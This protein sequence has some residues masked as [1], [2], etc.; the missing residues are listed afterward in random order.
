[1]MTV[2][3]VSRLTGVTVRTLQ[4]YDEIGLLPPAG[5]TE[6]GYRLYDRAAL[7]RLQQ[8]LLYRELRFPLGEIRR[9]LSAPDFDRDLALDQQ[10]G[11]LELELEHLEGL[12]RFARTI[13]TIGVR[14]LDFTAFDRKKQREYARRAKAQWGGSEAYR[15]YEEK[16]KGRSE[17]EE[18]G[19]AAGLMGIFRAFGAVKDGAPDSAE[20]Q[21]LVLQLQEYISANYYQ[22]TDEILAG[23]GQAYAAGGEF[24]ENIDRAGGPGTAA[25][26]AE[27]I[28]I[29][30]AKG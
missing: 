18:Q 24:T 4:Y 29:H 25:F 11:L 5:R 15:E 19:L 3:E 9:I 8:I 30:C 20:A 23:L 13:K 1:M 2:Q 28:R 21:A 6:A 7:E 10:I 27:A 12:I 17:A 26:A 14:E 22:C 16:S